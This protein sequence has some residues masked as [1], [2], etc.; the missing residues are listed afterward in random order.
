MRKANSLRAAIG[1][2]FI[3][4]C[5]VI[6]PA[7]HA[8]ADIIIDQF[9]SIA[10]PNP[11]PLIGTAVGSQNVVE[12]GL[13]N[14]I[15]GVRNTTLQT[16]LIGQPGLDLVQLTIDPNAFSNQGVLDLATTSQANAH[17]SLLY[18]GG[19]GNLNANFANEFA[20]MM[21]F[22]AADPGELGTILV[23]V[24]IDDGSQ[25]AS[26]SQTVEHFGP[27]GFLFSEFLGI[28]NVNLSSINSVR[29]DFQSFGFGG[30]DYRLDQIHTVVPSPASLC[31]FGLA[32]LGRRR[33]GL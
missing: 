2:L 26:S 14:V 32:L 4:A 24:T 17:L 1:A 33:R 13:S 3:S 12:T 18:D 21:T 22:F 31:V 19:S 9:N 16:N 10:A 6:L 23:T 25:N 7:S 20:I 11:W 5:G 29:I 15:G 27:V 28:R 30:V 8:E